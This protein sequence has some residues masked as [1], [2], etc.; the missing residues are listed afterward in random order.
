MQILTTILSLIGLYCI[1]AIFLPKKLLFFIQDEDGRKRWI[2]LV[3]AI[4]V[5]AIGFSISPA[6]EINAA[7]E[8]K[9][10]EQAAKEEARKRTRIAGTD[11]WYADQI[12]SAKADS[13]FFS[14]I[15]PSEVKVSE[16][17][18]E[19]MMSYLG[20]F[21]KYTDIE[22]TLRAYYDKN[23]RL[24]SLI[25]NN[26]KERRRIL[27][28]LLPTMRKQ[29]AEELGE[30]GWEDNLEVEV[31]GKGNTTLTLIK[32]DFASNRAIKNYQTQLEP[33]ARRFEF[34]RVEYKWIKHDPDYHYY[35]LE[36]DD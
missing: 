16:M 32:A 34:R 11:E 21:S 19:R 28:K 7:K 30:K 5:Y 14:R 12:R 26:A 29:F 22:D 27:S 17:D 15:D 24:A 2:P 25:K 31:K 3:A 6:P 36:Y 10:K 9:E 35:N 8:A 20:Q 23:D 18:G 4:V 13:A 1:V 33:I